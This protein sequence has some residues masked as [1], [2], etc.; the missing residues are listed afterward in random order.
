M[1]L[2]A[3]ST[4]I[5][6][7]EVM[8]SRSNF[9]ALHGTE[10]GDLFNEKFIVQH[11]KTF[12]FG[13]NLWTY[14]RDL[15]NGAESLQTTGPIDESVGVYILANQSYNG[16]NFTFNLRKDSVQNLS[17]PVYFWNFTDWGS[18]NVDCG[19]GQ[20]ERGVACWKI[21]PGGIV[22]EEEDRTKCD[23]SRRPMSERECSMELCQYRWVVSEWN[24]CNVTCG[25]GTH[26]RQLKC[27]HVRK[28]FGMGNIFVRDNLC[29]RDIQPDVKGICHAP[30]PCSNFY[31]SISPWSEVSFQPY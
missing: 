13:G 7:Q 22:E 6:I 9:L 1:T 4:H 14:E 19:R 31:W 10:S 2:P 16:I 5:H 3:G 21:S 26:R 17:G 20:Q 30:E 8:P 18:C 11:S 27:E 12:T 25:E 23:S 29:P 24:Q 15:Q 28:G